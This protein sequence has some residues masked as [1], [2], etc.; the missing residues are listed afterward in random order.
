LRIK[1][2]EDLIAWQKGQDLAVE[3]YELFGNNKD[4][5]FKDQICRASVSISNNIAEGFDRGSDADFSRFLNFSRTS[6]NEV[7]SMSYLARRLK[8]ISEE[9]KNAMIGQTE[10]VS[11]IIHGLIQSLLPRK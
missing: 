7:K 9:Q 3:V 10:E 1:R 6:C 8:Y 11:K 2:F 4:Y 5:G